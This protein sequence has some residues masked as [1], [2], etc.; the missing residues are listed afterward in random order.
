MHFL[1]NRPKWPALAVAMLAAGLSACLGQDFL[2]TPLGLDRLDHAWKVNVEPNEEFTV[3]LVANAL[4]Q[5]V[6][7]RLTGFD[8]GVVRFVTSDHIT[9]GCTPSEENPCPES[10]DPIVP[11]TLFRFV[12]ESAGE[13]PLDFELVVDGQVVDITE[14]TIA[15]VADACEG[16]V[17]ISANRCG[18]GNRDPDFGELTVNEHGSEMTIETA[19]TFTVTLAANAMHPDAPWQVTQIDPEVLRLQATA[20]DPARTPGDWDTS[21]RSK[22]WSFLPL[23][24]LTFEGVGAGESPLRLQ[25][26]VDGEPIEVFEVTVSVTGE[27]GGGA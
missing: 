12:G 18:L 24:R 6:P 14:Y 3:D 21:D 9:S 1:R 5:D 22:P 20:Q 23:W 16:D 11:H 19:E 27:G 8:P 26:A 25:A 7:W 4:Y 10:D 2:N 13:S 15:V 17:G